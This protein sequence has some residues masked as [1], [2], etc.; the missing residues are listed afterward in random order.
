MA[1]KADIVL[2]EPRV[3]APAKA[4]R[5]PRIDAAKGAAI[6]LVVLGHAKGIP[7]WFTVLAYSFH[8]PLFFLLSGW[9]SHRRAAHTVRQAVDTLARTL[10][11][12]Y[13]FF[14]LIAYAYWLLTRHIG[15]KAL[16]WGQS[17][18]W[19]P[20][21]GLLTGIGPKLYVHPALW[22]LPALFVIALAH[23]LL[24]KMLRTEAI[25]LLSLP[26][27]LAWILAFPGTGL[28]LPFA[29]DILPVGLFY[30]ACGAVAGRFV[31]LPRSAWA[32]CAA[33]LLLAVP[34]LLLAW[35]NGRVDIN[36]LRFG[37]SAGKFIM[38]SLLGTAIVLLASPLG[39]RSAAL[40]WIGR[41][42]LL[43]LCTHILVF[44]L[45]S[46][47]AS[48]AGLFPAGAKPGVAWAFGVSA[49]SIALCVP[50]RGLFLRYAP[51]ALG[52]RGETAKAA[53]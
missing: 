51:W 17:P 50:L 42:T 6:V 11:V 7:A 8:V 26:F 43:I 4:G 9:L 47:I 35:S 36:Q 31:S 32:G 19:E 29:L 3:A 1:A 34:W 45:L 52:L 21:I 49:F 23:L 27:A 14:F 40:Q 20:L 44:F 41:N 30:Y 10:L 38:A 25:A 5:D 37:A 2:A 22:F 18:W 48:F 12:P 13:L 33:A 24:S 39:A 16:R 28:R 46:G 15:E 53:A